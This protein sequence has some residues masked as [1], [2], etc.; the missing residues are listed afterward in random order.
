MPRATTSDPFVCSPLSF[1]CTVSP[2]ACRSVPSAGGTIVVAASVTALFIV[3]ISTFLSPLYAVSDTGILYNRS[4]SFS[5]KFSLHSFPCIPR[6]Q[7]W[8][9]CILFCIFSAYSACSAVVYSLSRGSSAS[10]SA[11]PKK[12]KA[13]TVRAR[14]R[15]G[16][17]RSMGWAS[18]RG[19]ASLI[20]RPQLG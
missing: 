20:M 10:L 3:V 2:K 6:I 11:S 17:R 12:L 1:T 19:M 15:P 14:R 4:Q 5:A 9:K 16:K 8:P 13:S 7:W 18:L